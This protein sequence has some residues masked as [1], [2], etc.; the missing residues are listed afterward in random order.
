MNNI[1]YKLLNNAMKEKYAI[2]SV[3][4]IDREMLVSYV[5]VV[6]NKKL[7]IIFSVAEAHL[8]YIDLEEAFWLANYYRKKYDLKAIIHLDHGKDINI[9][10][11]AIQ[12]GFDSVMIDGSSYEFNKNVELTKKV[13]ELAHEKDVFVEGEIGHVGSGE[14]VGTSC[15][16][17]DETIYTK[18]EDAINFV[19]LTGVDSLAISIGTTH[20]NYKNAPNINFER[21]KAIRDNVNIPLVLHGGSSSGDK[22]LSKCVKNGINKINLYTDFIVAAQKSVNN[23]IDYIGNKNNVRNA[24]KKVLEH[25]YSIFETK[26]I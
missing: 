16:E 15:S 13:V 24:I 25:Y 18:T 3:N 23:D 14:L 12:L 5:E 2:P 10:K 8:Q 17:V 9:I 1:S 4:F 26:E 19:K 22:N 6:K 20:G 21:L 11:H 7:P